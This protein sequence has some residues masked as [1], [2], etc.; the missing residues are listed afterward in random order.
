MYGRK[1]TKKHNG[2]LNTS[3]PNTIKAKKEF[4]F[5]RK[6]MT[7]DLDEFMINYFKS[8]SYHDIKEKLKALLDLSDN[9]ISV[10]MILLIN[11]DLTANKIS[12]ITGIQRTRIYEIFRRLKEKELIEL[13]SDNPQ[14][15]GAISPRTAID[16][17]SFKRRRRFEEESSKLSSLLP[18]LQR[19]W[20]DQ[21][22]ELLTRR[23]SLISEDYVREIIPQEI[24]IARNK[25]CLALR[26]P[27]PEKAQLTHVRLFDPRGFSTGIQSFLKRGVLLHIL[28]GDLELF[29]KKS[30][31]FLLRT[32]LKGLLDGTI[33]VRALGYLLPQSF[34]IVDD[35]RIFL[36]FLN[37]QNDTYNEAIRAETHSIREF[38]KI[39]WQKFWEEAT[40]LNIETVIKVIDSEKTT[41]HHP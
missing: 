9:E 12:K 39:I 25:I 40:P 36:F 35:E 17:F 10:Y 4:N 7:S 3:D 27:V 13:L 16:N 32:L 38:F 41:P 30:H 33:E 20:N 5:W 1:S 23:I 28:I 22:E 18:T 15:Y 2:H 26:D 24:K 37:T 34:L 6:L 29:L 8:S 21:H 14:R 31:P 19:L 11:Y